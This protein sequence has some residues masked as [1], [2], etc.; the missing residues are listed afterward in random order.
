MVT[1]ANVAMKMANPCNMIARTEKY[2]FSTL[3]LPSFCHKTDNDPQRMTAWIRLGSAGRG[4]LWDRFW[5]QERRVG[6]FNMV[7]IS[8]NKA[9]VNWKFTPSKMDGSSSSL[10]PT[11]LLTRPSRYSWYIWNSLRK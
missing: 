1:M 10:S 9:R 3:G 6:R 11:A 2:F 4:R 5:L 7:T 8:H